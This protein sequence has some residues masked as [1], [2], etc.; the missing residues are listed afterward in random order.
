SVTE[1]V[2]EGSSRKSSVAHTHLR[3]VPGAWF[4][5]LRPFAG[6]RSGSWQRTGTSMLAARA[7]SQSVVPA[8][9]V[10][11]WPSMVRWIRVVTS[12]IRLLRSHVREEGF[13]SLERV[14]EP[15]LLEGAGR[16]SLVAEEAHFRTVDRLVR[17]SGPRDVQHARPAATPDE[18]PD[19]A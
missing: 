7:A 11:A 8:G 16:W 15:Y 17:L 3:W 4:L 1:R 2:L 12:G 19:A 10:T 5:V 14:S 13:S 6:R 9:T 18:Q